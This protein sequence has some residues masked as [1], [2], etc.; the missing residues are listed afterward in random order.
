MN[1]PK[2]T[3]QKLDR[4][5]LW[6]LVG[7][8]GLAGLLLI[9]TIVMTVGGLIS[10][11]SYYL[12]YGTSEIIA[13]VVVLV[14]GLA[15]LGNLSIGV[16]GLALSALDAREGYPGTGHLINWVFL[17]ATLVIVLFVFVMVFLSM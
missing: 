2:D 4:A 11:D 9:L 14:Y 7:E 12:D 16:L 13:L 8:F 1:T 10:Y 3:Y 15:Y 17:S 6:L 5:A